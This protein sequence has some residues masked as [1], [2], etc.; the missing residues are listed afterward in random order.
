MKYMDI[1][2]DWLNLVEI[3][4]T[5]G[6][7]S[8]NWTDIMKIIK[9]ERE[10]FY[11]DVDED[12]MSKPAGWLFLS[13]EGSDSEDGEEEDED[14]N[15]SSEQSDSDASESDSDDDESDFSESEEDSYDE[16]EEEGLE[17]KGMV[18]VFDAF[19]HS[20][21]VRAA[22]KSSTDSWLLVYYSS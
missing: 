7:R 1:I 19:G 12:G 16:E 15:F 20:E 4:F 22:M 18:S 6:P 14:S 8:I 10:T 17:E 2:Q 13:A 11:E 3:T 21:Y 5:K 9:E